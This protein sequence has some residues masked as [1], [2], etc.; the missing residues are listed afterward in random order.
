MIFSSS[1]LA[2]RYYDLALVEQ[3]GAIAA[4]AKAE[5]LAEVGRK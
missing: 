3:F 2:T 1:T 4:V 5:S